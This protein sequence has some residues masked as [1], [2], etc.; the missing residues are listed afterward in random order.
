LVNNGN[1]TLFSLNVSSEMRRI[2][3]V[4]NWQ[5]SSVNFNL[6]I[7]DPNG[8]ILDI[9]NLNTSGIVPIFLSNLKS[10]LL[11]FP[12]QGLWYFNLTWNNISNP[13]IIKSRL[14]TYDP[15]IYIQSIIQYNSSENSILMNQI[16]EVKDAI[17]SQTKDFLSKKLTQLN[18]SIGNQSVIFLINVTNKN[19]LF[20]YHNITPYLLGN[21]SLYNLT[22]EWI[23]PVAS[24]LTIGQFLV[25]QFNLTF[26]EPTLL[27]GTLFFK[28]NC[29][30]GYYDAIAQDVALDYRVITENVTIETYLEN[31]TITIIE[32]QTIVVT[33]N[34]TIQTTIVSQMMTMV[35]KYTY[36]KQVFDTLKWAGFFISLGLIMSFLAV[37]VSA[38]AIRIRSFA[39]MFRS[40]LFP[41]QSALE[42]ALQEQGIDVSPT[43]LSAVIDSTVNLDQFGENIFSLTGKRLTPEDLIRLT[44]GVAIDQIINRL[45]FVT[46]LSPSEIAEKLQA[47]PSV[48]H[49]IRE[50][51]LDQEKF[52]DIITKDE[53][54]IKFQDKISSLIGPK[55]IIQSDVVVND[56]IDIFAF[57]GKIRRK[58]S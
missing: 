47:A 33:E 44:S 13:E 17:N 51:N 45:S 25:F 49:L 28:V 23:P 58:F 7:I 26:L 16:K 12:Q 54:V 15:P 57:R 42:L 18:N 2:K 21:F 31:Q 46:G 36:N 30:E 11:D 6:T 14:L 37:Y 39:K 8:S 50:L 9:Q 34:Q 10:V 52:L 20:T 38:Q 53:Q 3:W 27:Q 24:N 56:D 1:F 40:R 41:D 55:V 22:I 32:N 4:L 29:T 35:T 43:E 19:P 5:D 48:E